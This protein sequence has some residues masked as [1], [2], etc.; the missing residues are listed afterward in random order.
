[1]VGKPKGLLSPRASIVSLLGFALIVLSYL[2]FSREASQALSRTISPD[3]NW[4]VAIDEIEAGNS[5]GAT[6]Y[7]ISIRENSWFG[8]FLNHKILESESF[9]N[10]PI[11]RAIW[12]NP[13]LLEIR[14]ISKSMPRKPT[15]HWKNITIIFYN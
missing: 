12:K 10:V 9:P 15:Q 13:S 2:F 5:F 8:F 7:K 11:P 3:S 6:Y 14:S 1:M 4:V